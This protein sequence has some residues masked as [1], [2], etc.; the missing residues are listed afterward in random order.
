MLSHPKTVEQTI[1]NVQ[2]PPRERKP[3]P[4]QFNSFQNLKSLSTSKSEQMQYHTRSLE[5]PNYSHPNDIMVSVRSEHEL[6]QI[7]NSQQHS[8]YIISDYM[9]KIATRVNLLETELKYAWRALDLLSTEYGKIWVRLEKLENISIEQQ[10]VVSNLMDLIEG[11]NK[12]TYT[13]HIKEQKHNSFDDKESE[14]SSPLQKKKTLDK[15]VIYEIDPSNDYSDHEIFSRERE[16]DHEKQVFLNDASAQKTHFGYD[17]DSYK[18]FHSENVEYPFNKTYKAEQFQENIVDHDKETRKKLYSES[19]LLLYQKRQ[20]LA[21]NARI[22]LMKEFLNGRRVLNEI[23][24]MAGIS[25]PTSDLTIPTKP[26][27]NNAINS[28]DE[29]NSLNTLNDCNKF[30]C[31]T[32]YKTDD[33]GNQVLPIQDTG[34]TAFSVKNN[35]M[36][37]FFYR[38][39]NEAYREN[40]LSLEISKVDAILQKSEVTHEQIKLMNG[41]SSFLTSNQRS[42]ETQTP[43]SESKKHRKKK[44]HTNEMDMINKLKGIL[45]HAQSPII[46]CNTNENID[47]LIKSQRTDIRDMAGCV[48]NVSKTQ[49]FGYNKSSFA[50]DLRITLDNICDTIIDEINKIPG[51]QSLNLSQISEIRQT[52]WSEELFFQKLSQVDE[53]LTLLLLNPITLSEELRRVNI[54][55]SVEKFVLVMKK[56]KKNIDTLKKLVCSSLDDYKKSRRHS[57]VSKAMS[58]NSINSF[59][60]PKENQGGCSAELLRTKSDLNE[61]LKIIETQEIEICRK[62]KIDQIVSSQSI[63]SPGILSND[64][65]YQVFKHP[66]SNI[67]LLSSTNK[68]Y[69]EDEYIK[70]LKKSLDRHNSML[71][72]LHFQNPEKHNIM[73][74]IND[75]V[76]NPAQINISPPPPAPNDMGNKMESQKPK[77][78]ES[79][80]D[81]S[82]IR[83][84][85]MKS[86]ENCNIQT[87]S[88]LNVTEHSSIHTEASHTYPTVSLETLDSLNNLKDLDYKSDLEKS[89]NEFLI[90]D[91]NLSYIQELSKNLPICSAYENESIFDANLKVERFFSVDEILMWD[92][93][94]EQENSNIRINKSEIAMPDLLTIQSRNLVKSQMVKREKEYSPMASKKCDEIKESCIGKI[95]YEEISKNKSYRSHFN[96]NLVYYPSPIFLTKNNSSSSLNISG[97]SNYIPIIENDSLS[98]LAFTSQAPLDDVRYNANQCNDTKVSKLIP[99]SPCEQKPIYLYNTP[100]Q[101]RTSSKPPKLWNKLFSENLKLKGTAKYNRSQSL[102]GNMQSQGNQGQGCDQAGSCP[103]ISLKRLNE[104]ENQR[105]LSKRLQKLPMRILKRATGSPFVR[106]FSHQNI[107]IPSSLYEAPNI[108]NTQTQ[109]ES[110]SSKMSHIMQKAKSYKRRSVVLS[111]KCNILGSELDI[112]D[113]TSADNEFS[114]CDSEISIN[115]YDSGSSPLNTIDNQVE[116]CSVKSITEISSK[117]L[118]SVVGDIRKNRSL[119]LDAPPHEHALSTEAKNNTVKIPEMYLQSNVDSET[120]PCLKKFNSI[121]IDDEENEQI[122]VEQNNDDD[123]LSSFKMTASDSSIKKFI[124]ISVNIPTKTTSTRSVNSSGGQD[125]L[126]QSLEIP[127]NLGCGLRDDDDNRSQHSTRTLSSSRRQSTEDSIDTDDEYFYYELR[128]L[129]NMEHKQEESSPYSIGNQHADNKILF[130]QIGQLLRNNVDEGCQTSNALVEEVERL[131][132]KPDESVKLQMSL[133]LSEL[134][135]IVKLKPSIDEENLLKT[136]VDSLTGA[137]FG[138]NLPARENLELVRDMHK[139]WQDVNGDFR[140]QSNTLTKDLKENKIHKSALS[141]HDGSTSSSENG[142]EYEAKIQKKLFQN[143]INDGNVSLQSSES[144]ITSGPDTPAQLSDEM[145]VACLLME[146]NKIKKIRGDSQKTTHKN[147]QQFGE[148]LSCK[149][150]IK[151]VV[152]NTL[153]DQV[154]NSH[155]NVVNGSTAG[156]SNSKWKLLKT[157]KERKIEE[158]NNQDKKRE[159]TSTKEKEKVITIIQECYFKIFYFKIKEFILK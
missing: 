16:T 153:T 154:E 145:E 30:F 31:S 86:P 113:S 60:I 33:G 5:A 124:E 131:S 7:Y 137:D 84:W 102:P 26:R 159:E 130:S 115:P 129:E 109:K 12:G 41:S 49:N 150:K 66:Q 21:N 149:N 100:E 148:T 106:R 88:I 141:N 101:K 68:T 136:T 13:D 51:L 147:P 25:T 114:L 29:F 120:I 135:C 72:L 125:L 108:Y 11:A 132:F 4:L 80:S 77:K 122:V 151:S 90:S 81:L 36:G 96:D 28:T 104:C 155:S 17:S 62:Q 55:S 76:I 138:E 93:L 156:L 9:D 14:Q 15:D 152:S 3:Q 87:N 74:D 79:N 48:S 111:H 71:F 83:G 69:S 133:V 98:R 110:F 67:E 118:F 38:K 95:G 24:G 85:W 53:K 45:S 18:S 65:D 92:H 23:S 75:I 127:T 126:Q 97:Q 82:S 35:E 50:D 140:D 27:I 52:I 144:S 157:L 89:K 99:E 42:L 146:E 6:C 32:A 58:T 19:D 119:L 61:Q 134:K 54:T 128:K 8:D 63:N 105:Q 107:V 59:L 70:S 78:E 139:A 143:A 64:S 46:N 37:E 40:D 10:S 34:G 43:T 73:S 158:K 117:N 1:P 47:D 94:K 91:E 20:V 44:H 121:F 103:L 2:S 56:F 39:L 57:Y 142:S 123:N 22:E 116:K 112:P